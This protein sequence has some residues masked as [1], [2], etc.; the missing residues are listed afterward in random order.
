M[1][2]WRGMVNMLLISWEA[3]KQELKVESIDGRYSVK[4]SMI[5]LM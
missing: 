5:V 1:S 2:K 3:R 4:D